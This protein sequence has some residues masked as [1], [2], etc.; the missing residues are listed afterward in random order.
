[1]GTAVLSRGVAQP[2]LRRGTGAGGNPGQEQQSDQ[3]ALAHIPVYP[4]VTRLSFVYRVVMT[5]VSA[6]TA[7]ASGAPP[8][9]RIVS[10]RIDADQFGEDAGVRGV[11]VSSV[12][13]S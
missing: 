11:R 5:V 6:G 9:R 3:R 2:V 12:R 4:F 1:M 10:D 13:V 7:H 8:R